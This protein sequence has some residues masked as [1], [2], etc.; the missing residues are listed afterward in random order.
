MYGEMKVGMTG[1]RHGL[2]QEQEDAFLE[3][4]FDGITEFHHGDCIGADEECHRIIRNILPEVK[5]VVHPPSIIHGQAFMQ[6]DESRRPE[7]YLIRNKNIVNE[8]DMLIALPDGEERLRSGTWST[9][10]YAR[11][12]FRPITIIYSSGAVRQEK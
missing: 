9:V 5:I 10:R 4:N 2:T 1:T 7:A 11:K 8:T 6:G 3:I 12:L